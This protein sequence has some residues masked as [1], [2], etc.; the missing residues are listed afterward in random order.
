MRLVLDTDKETRFTVGSRASLSRTISEKDVTTYA[1][2]SGDTSPVHI[3]AEY[4]RKTRFGRKTAHDM[5]AVGLISSLLKTRLPG[6]GVVCLSQQLEFLGP[7]FVGDTITA[8]VE[9]AAWQPEKNLVTLKTECSNQDARQVI[10]GQAVL[11]LT[12][13]VME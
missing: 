6:T 13:E 3:D 10:T 11:M 5:L 1:A 7:I 9:V 8:Q 12:K 2:L 4:A